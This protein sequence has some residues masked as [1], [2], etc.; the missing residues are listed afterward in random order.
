M[1]VWSKVKG[2]PCLLGQFG[3]LKKLSMFSLESLVQNLDSR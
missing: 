1:A 2:R 3:S